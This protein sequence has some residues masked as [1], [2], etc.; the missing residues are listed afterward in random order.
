RQE[1]VPDYACRRPLASSERQEEGD[2]RFTQRGLLGRMPDQ[3]AAY[4]IAG[5]M[6][7]VA[8]TPFVDPC[9]RTIRV[10]RG[11]R[12][13]RPQLQPSPNGRIRRAAGIN[14]CAVLAG[15]AQRVEQ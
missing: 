5:R 14:A 3:L 13:E 6:V 7:R 9:N 4:Q 1:T 12:R 2:V 8:A 11:R 15:I 10:A